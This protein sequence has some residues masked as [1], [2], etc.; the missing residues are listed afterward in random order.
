M[1]D[2]LLA[3]I[4]VGVMIAGGLLA[5][6]IIAIVKSLMNKMNKYIGDE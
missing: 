5:F 6:A 1:S 3:L 4:F 2:G